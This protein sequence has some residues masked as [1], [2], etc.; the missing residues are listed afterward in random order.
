MHY[1]KKFAA[2]WQDG[3]REMVTQVQKYQNHFDKVY[4]TNINQ[5]PYIYLLFY[6]KYDPEKFINSGG[7]RDYFDKYVF[8]PDDVN[9]YD[10]ILTA[11]RRQV[12]ILYVA[13]SWEKVDG[14]WLA[15]ANDSTGRHIYSLWD[16][17]ETFK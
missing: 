15:A 3:Y 6:G 4:I 17:N 13:P 14:K 16:L 8:I 7:N 12:R 5:V 10:Q 11:D 1:P 9:I 2:D